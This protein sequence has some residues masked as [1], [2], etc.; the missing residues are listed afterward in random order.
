MPTCR[1]IPA[2][3]WEHARQALVFYF[4]RR[5]G[6]S[7]AED[8]AQEALATLWGREDYE[9]Q[10]EEDFLRVC[11]GFARLVS[12]QGYRRSQKHAG[13]EMDGVEPAPS[14]GE[15]SAVQTEMR[16]LLDQVCRMGASKLNEKDWELIRHAAAGDR[17]AAA[18]ALD[19]GDANNLRVR[20]HRARKRL[21][22]LTG[23]GQ[24]RV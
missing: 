13:D 21:A 9:F 20:L 6:F 18:E 17:A 2:E 15:G 12:L 24:D 22:R 23:W 16:I 14:Q 3:A 1:S 4:S 5:H 11:F 10:K 7:D 8:L 19:I